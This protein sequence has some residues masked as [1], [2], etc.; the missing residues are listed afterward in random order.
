[1]DQNTQQTTSNR[2]GS[3]TMRIEELPE[4]RF[5]D[6]LQNRIEPVSDTR[7][8]TASPFTALIRGSDGRLG[9]ELLEAARR[10]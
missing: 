5:P 1:M 7:P 3:N 8:E 6:A 9:G 2:H 4:K 10:G